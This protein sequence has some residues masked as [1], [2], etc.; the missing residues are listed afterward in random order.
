MHPERLG[1]YQI[2]AATGDNTL[3]AT[4]LGNDPLLKRKVV[5][6]TVRVD[7]TVADRSDAPDQFLKDI[8][9]VERLSHVNIATVYDCGREGNLAYIATE[10]L[11]GRDLRELIVRDQPV[12]AELAVDIVAGVADGLAYAHRHGVIHQNVAPAHITVLA[13]GGVKLAGFG[14]AALQTGSQQAD[15]ALQGTTAY[16][17]P[18][19][20]SGKRADARTDIFS[21]A[22]ILYQLLTGKPPFD[23]DNAAEVM[24]R[25]VRKPARWPSRATRL[26]HRGFDFIL[27]R[28]LAK[29]PDDR[30]PSA[31]EFA[32]DLRRARELAERTPLPWPTGGLAQ[33][34][35]SGSGHPGASRDEDVNGTLAS[36]TSSRRLAYAVVGVALAA[37]LAFIGW[38]ATRPAPVPVLVAPAA[39]TSPPAT[40]SAQAPAPSLPTPVVAPVIDGTLRP[41][42]SAPLQTVAP[43][44]TTVAAAAS[45]ATPPAPVKPATVTLSIAPWGEVFVN[46]QSRGISPPL[47][48]LELPPG[49]VRIEI[50]NTGA[51]TLVKELNL[52]AG[53]TVRLKHKF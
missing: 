9:V 3:G 33:R 19:Q 34:K 25:I 23:G 38:N 31:I 40:Q 53:K 43:A 10:F 20:F 16:L 2:I 26:E 14:I 36:L 11:E 45:D 32:A 51:P 41:A 28:A 1:R 47:T 52:D 49:P 50:R 35:S 5:L 24:Y 6:Q 15:A 18:E 8:K 37:G 46:N 29:L 42:P 7:P 44:T 13:N 22:V 48:R 30:Y 39:P 12:P 21:L 27:A 17:A 4:Y